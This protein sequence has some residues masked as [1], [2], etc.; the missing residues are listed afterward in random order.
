M[1][2]ARVDLHVHSNYSDGRDSVEK[3]I[4]T[5]KGRGL[6]K[7]AIVDHGPDH[8]FGMKLEDIEKRDEEISEFSK[9]YGID[10]FSGI[11][12]DLDR[13]DSLDMGFWNDN[14][15]LI[16]GSIHKRYTYGDY[17][18]YV[19]RSIKDIDILAH[20]GWK[21]DGYN[22]DIEVELIRLL[23]EHDVAVE[24]NSRRGLPWE[25]FLRMCSDAGLKYSI[26]SDAHRAIHVGNVEW[27]EDIASKFFSEEDI[28]LGK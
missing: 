10:V 7:V 6:Y 2:K 8:Q 28:Y 1:V 18:Q 12:L 20:H 15:D 14:F 3:L 19:K 11:E 9:F 4:E 25:Y 23:K 13:L 16:L 27:A 17:F 5:A 21:I 22:D 26:G 24:I